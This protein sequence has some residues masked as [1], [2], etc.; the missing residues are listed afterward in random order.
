MANG[1]SGEL[2]G[3]NAPALTSDER[4]WISGFDKTAVLEEDGKL[5]CCRQLEGRD[6]A[7]MG[8]FCYR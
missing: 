8:S 2:G 6:L 3:G 4:R 7:S 1:G 5:V